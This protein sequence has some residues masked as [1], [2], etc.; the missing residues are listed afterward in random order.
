MQQ[1]YDI[2]TINIPEGWSGLSSYLMPTD[3]DIENVFAP[4]EDDLVIAMTME[5]YYYPFYNVNTIGSWEQH[6]AYKVK[7]TDAISLEIIGNMEENKTVALGDGWNLLPVVADCPVD[8]EDLFA[9]VAADL[10]IVKEV[11][12][13][14]LYWP[15]M[16]INN[17]GTMNPGEAYYVLA[18][19]SISVTFG[20][21]K[22]AGLENLPGFTGRRPGQNPEGLSPWGLSN[23]TPAS[24]SIAILPDAIKGFEPGSIIGAFDVNGNCFGIIPIDGSATCLTIFGDDNLSAEKDGFAES[25]HIFIKIYKPSTKEEFGLIPEFDFS[26]PNIDGAFVENGLSAITGFKAGASGSIEL[27]WSSTGIY[28]NPSSGIFNVTGLHSEAQ[29]KITDVHGQ[30]VYSNNALMADE[31]QIDLGHCLPGI[32]LVSIWQNNVRTYHK[33]ILK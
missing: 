25:E 32:Y 4:I 21:C 29:V 3:T 11:A 22:K 9:P 19:N 27:G 6:S 33:L 14:G 13:Y 17:L 7:V 1:T 5:D 16:G 23:P 18:S 12:G 20:D 2:H 31:N 28:P 30:E 10:E 15:D 26:L 8:V 24:H